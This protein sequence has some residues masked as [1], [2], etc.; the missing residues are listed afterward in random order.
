MKQET[1][2]WL[3]EPAFWK[4]HYLVETPGE[5]IEATLHSLTFTSDNREWELMSL[6]TGTEPTRA[7]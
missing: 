5:D 3:K 1:E 6:D 7:F 2:P 4:S